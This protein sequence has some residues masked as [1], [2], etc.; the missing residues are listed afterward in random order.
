MNVTLWQH[1]KCHRRSFRLERL[2]VKPQ[3][4]ARES[5]DEPANNAQAYH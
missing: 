4:E 2:V 1:P 5:V 3:R